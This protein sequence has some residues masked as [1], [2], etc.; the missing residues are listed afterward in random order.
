MN[1]NAYELFETDKKVE[2]DG[3]DIDYGEF[4][5]KIARSGGAN[6]KYAKTLEIL[7]KPHR[8]AIQTE[9]ADVKLVQKLLVEAHAKAVVLGWTGVKDRE[10]KP[11][12]FSVDNCIKLFNDLPDLFSDVQ[13]QAAKTGL[14][15]KTV[16]EESSG[17]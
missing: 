10:G 4:Q 2:E 5:I 3:I 6:Q 7:T 9:T 16:I 12:K 14:F 1:M 17:N 13:E 8:R 11:M 15:R